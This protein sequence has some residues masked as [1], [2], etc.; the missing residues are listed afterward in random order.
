MMDKVILISI[1][2]TTIKNI[3]EEAVLKAI[4]NIQIGQIEDTP[5]SF[6]EAMDYLGYS[7]SHGYKLT[8]ANQIPHSKRGKQ[9]FFSKSEL[10]NW[11]LSNKVKTTKQIDQEAAQI[12]K[13]KGLKR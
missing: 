4:G 11:L 1:P 3:V 7:R 13:S 9:L 12:L 10:D 6:K 5:M 2:E 8:S